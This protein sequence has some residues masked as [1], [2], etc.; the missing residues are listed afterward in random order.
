MLGKCKLSVDK[1]KAFGVLLTYVY[2][3]F[4]CLLHDLIIAKLSAY[5]FSLYALKLM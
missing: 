1:G 4:D 2:K 3:A 5:G